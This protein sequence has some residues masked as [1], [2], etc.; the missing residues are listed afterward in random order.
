MPFGQ[1]DGINAAQHH[2]LPARFMD[3]L[4]GEVGGISHLHEQRGARFVAD[5]EPRT[6]NGQLA[7]EQHITG[8]G[9]TCKR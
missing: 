2:P 4:G 9:W 8:P 5:V 6:M 7:H 3:L 1:G